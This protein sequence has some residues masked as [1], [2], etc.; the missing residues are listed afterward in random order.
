MA[1]QARR[2]T[3][4]ILQWEP[5]WQNMR[6]H[7]LGNLMKRLAGNAKWQLREAVQEYRKLD[8]AYAG[9]GFSVAK[10]TKNF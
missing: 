2:L 8:A 1:W 4:G 9:M 6:L 7:A 5:Y 3:G 10:P